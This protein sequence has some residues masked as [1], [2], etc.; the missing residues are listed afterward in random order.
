M[1][2]RAA[3]T[4]ETKRQD[5]L[6]MRVQPT[7]RE[8]CG[9]GLLESNVR[10]DLLG[11]LRG[12]LF[13]SCFLSDTASATET[14]FFAQHMGKKGVTYRK[15]FNGTKSYEGIPYEGEGAVKA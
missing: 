11:A 4:A 10:C 5:W 3:A 7:E 14:G 8:I 6:C 12:K 9:S 13:Y 2:F 1:L 15:G